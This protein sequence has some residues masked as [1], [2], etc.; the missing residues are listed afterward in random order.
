MLIFL[1]GDTELAGRRREE[2]SQI[3]T[4]P[5]TEPVTADIGDLRELPDHRPLITYH[6]VIHVDGGDGC[7]GGSPGH[8]R[9]GG[10]YF[11]E[12]GKEEV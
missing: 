9:R 3:L 1:R 11:P 6:G 8:Q 12:S 2:R 7:F 10:R 4:I 5:A